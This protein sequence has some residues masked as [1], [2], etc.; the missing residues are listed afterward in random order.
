M[1][2]RKKKGEGLDPV[3]PDQ[4]TTVVKDKPKMADT[5]NSI[6]ELDSN[7]ADFDDYVPLPDGPYGAACILAEV[8]TSDK[9]NQYFYTNW[10]IPVSAYPADYE[11][12]NAPE[13]TVV[14]Y[15]RVQVPSADDRRSITN[16]KK[17]MSAMG[18]SLKTSRIDCSEWVGKTANLVIGHEEYNGEV[19]NRVIGVENE[20]A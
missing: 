20:N 10:R 16:V 17:L 1:A 19:R 9:G 8:R 13:G 3:V 4:S 12:A 6:I 15:S 5:Q 18:L 2:P 11:V 14:N 7:L